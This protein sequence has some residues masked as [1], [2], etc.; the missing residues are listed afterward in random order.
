MSGTGDQGDE[1]RVR[2]AFDTD[3]VGGQQVRRERHA[4]GVGRGGRRRG[5]AVGL[6]FHGDVGQDQS[7]REGVVPGAAQPGKEQEHIVATGEEVDARPQD[8]R[9]VC[10]HVVRRTRVDDRHAFAVCSSNAGHIV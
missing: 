6:S 5:P 8:T 10:T 7:Q 4:G 3:H 1:G 2:A 9:E